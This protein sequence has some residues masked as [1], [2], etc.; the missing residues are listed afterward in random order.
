MGTSGSPRTTASREWSRTVASQAL[1]TPGSVPTALTVGPDRALWFADRLN[2]RIGRIGA[3]ASAKTFSLDWASGP[4]DIAAGPDGALWFTDPTAE[5]IG[6]MTLDGVIRTPPALPA[7]SHPS[8]LA[9]GPD[10]Q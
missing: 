3:E 1:R 9:A 8:G 6:R 2:H 5:V 7:G 10:G 4:W